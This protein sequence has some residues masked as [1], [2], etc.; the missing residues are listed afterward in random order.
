[1]S[2]LRLL[3]T[4]RSLVGLRN[5]ESPY[6]LSHHRLVPNFGKKPNPFRATTLPEPARTVPLALE[7]TA[8]KLPASP[9]AAPAESTVAPASAGTEEASPTTVAA[10]EVVPSKPAGSKWLPRNWTRVHTWF[11]RS[12]KPAVVRSDRVTKPA[13]QGEL[14]LE[15]IQVVRNDLRDSD[16]EVVPAQ[17]PRPGPNLASTSDAGPTSRMPEPILVA[18]S[19]AGAGRTAFSR[20]SARIFGAAKL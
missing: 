13:V 9:P 12:A 11:R 19:V 2:L 15:G 8:V 14:S 4:G 18:R 3:T 5:G 7:S 20:M 1:M 6:R 17:T 10:K 16:L